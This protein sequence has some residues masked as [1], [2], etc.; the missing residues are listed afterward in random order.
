M[1][2]LIGAALLAAFLAPIPAHAETIDLATIK[3]SELA[4]IQDSDG[5]FL[6]TWLLGYQAGQAGTTTMDLG[7]MESIGKNIGEYCAA[8]PDVGVLAASTTAMQE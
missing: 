6:F 1:K 8:N 4:T 3:C 2:K 5:T 7:A